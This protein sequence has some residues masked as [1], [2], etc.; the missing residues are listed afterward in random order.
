MSKMNSDEE[1]KFKDRLNVINQT[2]LAGKVTLK[3]AFQ[4][5]LVPPANKKMELF[6]TMEKLFSLASDM[7]R[8]LDDKNTNEKNNVNINS[9]LTDLMKKE[10]GDI[11]EQ[12]LKENT[13]TSL[14]S[15]TALKQEVADDLQPME[16]HKLVME[17]VG[18]NEDPSTDTG[19]V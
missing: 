4:A 16:T 17:K 5:G 14:T 1:R 10:I 15:G 3:A 19:K 9:G 11:I 7:L 12:K 13:H 2:S 18:N 6:N 8:H